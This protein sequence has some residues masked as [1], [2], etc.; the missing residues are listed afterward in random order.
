MVRTFFAIALSQEEQQF[1]QQ[2]VK[3]LSIELGDSIRWLRPE[4]WHITL[5]FLGNVDNAMIDY[6]SQSAKSL[7]TKVPAFDYI[8]DKI[9]GFPAAKSRM[10]AVYIEPHAILEHLSQSLDQ[11]AADAGLAREERSF[12]PHITLAKAHH[13]VAS[14]VPILLEGVT[15]TAKELVLYESKPSDEGSHYTPIKKFAFR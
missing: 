4:N 8:G 12:K 14:F 15:F 2:V 1:I 13:R 7:A 9:A 5:R 10:V 6:M 3:A 11:A